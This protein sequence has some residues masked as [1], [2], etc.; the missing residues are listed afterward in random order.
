LTRRATADETTR[1]TLS[2]YLASAYLPPGPLAE[3]RDPPPVSPEVAQLGPSERRLVVVS[4]ALFR[5]R[6]W[7]ARRRILLAFPTLLVSGD[8]EHTLQ[9]LG[10][11]MP[12]WDSVRRQLAWPV[13]A[14]AR[15][16][17]HPQGRLLPSPQPQKAHRQAG[18]HGFRASGDGQRDCGRGSSISLGVG[19]PGGPRV[20][21]NPLIQSLFRGPPEITGPSTLGLKSL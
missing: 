12:G 7:E 16:A 3:Y 20:G 15:G 4:L 21:C 13:S 8:I 6:A 9:V 19:G 18:N 2:Q 1:P 17:T 14:G 10:S 11:S 5:A